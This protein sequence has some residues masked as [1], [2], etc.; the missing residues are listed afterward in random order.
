MPPPLPD[1]TPPAHIRQLE[2]KMYK[3]IQAIHSKVDTN[4]LAVMHEIGE[5]AKMMRRL[6]NREREAK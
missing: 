6:L 3:E 2:H 4:H 1:I 5:L